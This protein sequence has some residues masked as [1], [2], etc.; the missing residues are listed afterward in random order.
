M[1]EPFS[2]SP[3]RRVVLDVAG[4]DTVLWGTTIVRILTDVPCPWRAAKN[5]GTYVIC[6][7]SYIDI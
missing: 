2:D 4:T 1:A 7:I 3:S 6:D 5:R